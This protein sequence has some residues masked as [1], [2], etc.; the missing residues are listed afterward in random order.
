MR[1]IDVRRE[2]FGVEPICRAL[3]WA[4]STFYAA[5]TRPR[6]RRAERDLVLT[7]HIHRVWQLNQSVY[8][9]RKVW[10]QL[11]REGVPVARCTVQRLM[12]R[13]GLVGN[14]R[15]KRRKTT[16]PDAAA[17]RPADLVDRRF[18]AERPNQLWVADITYISTWSGVC[19]A[20][21]VIDVYSRMVVGWAITTHLRTELALEALEM[22]I[23]RRNAILEGLIHHSDRGSQYTSIRYTERLAEAGIEPSVGSRGDSYDNALAE[24]TIGLYKSEWIE[25][26]RPWKTPEE[27][28]RSTLDW[29]DWW[30]N[31]RLHGSIGDVPPAEFEA[32]YYG[33]GRLFEEIEIQR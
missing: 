22:A 5:K 7:S 29:I 18:V 17:S 33:Q 13:D 10:K 23:W 2:R 28:E 30:N 4:P 12:R 32:A 16:I 21:L 1:F 14:R 3:G 27:V 9:L 24:S 31:R 26:K 25:R 11:H 6:S 15:G 20:A 8:G 19:Y